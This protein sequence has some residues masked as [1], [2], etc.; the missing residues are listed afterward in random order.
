MSVKKLLSTATKTL[1]AA[2]TVI[3][4]YLLLIIF[5]IKMQLERIKTMKKGFLS[6]ERRRCTLQSM[7]K[8]QAILLLHSLTIGSSHREWAKNIDILA[9]RYTV[10]C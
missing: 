5:V 1:A 9:K 3:F 8:R 2:G 7:R 6:M 4:L 10:C